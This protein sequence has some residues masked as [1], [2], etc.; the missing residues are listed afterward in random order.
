[1]VQLTILNGKKAGA[2]WLARRFPFRV[3]RAAA[4]ELCLDDDG[5][6]DRH[7]EFNVKPAA[8]IFLAAQPEALTSVNGLPVAESVLRNGDLI[9][10]GSLRLRFWLAPTRQ[11]GLRLRECLT[12]LALALVSLGQVALIYWLLD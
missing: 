5:V 10:I 12:W 6:W 1:V 8:G 2:E 4:C 9:E 3:G 7:L 11:R